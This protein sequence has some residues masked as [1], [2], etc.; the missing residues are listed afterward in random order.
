MVRTI[1][2]AMHCHSTM[3]PCHGP[4]T[5][6][7]CWNCRWRAASVAMLATAHRP[8]FGRVP[9]MRLQRLLG[10]LVFA[11]AACFDAAHAAAPTMFTAG[12][13]EVR[14][15]V[16]VST[17]TGYA[18]TFGGG[19]WKTSDAG[20][21]WTK[22]SLIAKSVWKISANSASVGA[23]LYAATESGLFRS[24]DSGV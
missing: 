17:T 10:A 24:T 4:P 23:R 6:S 22:T 16:A 5:P 11:A 21:N 2:A 20:A 13:G 3:I 19:L 18:A 14:D 9:A 1:E 8:A 15:F 7:R 12:A